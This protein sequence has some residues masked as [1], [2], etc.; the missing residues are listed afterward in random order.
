VAG[1]FQKLQELA[2]IQYMGETGSLSMT[3]HPPVVGDEPC[4]KS[5]V[6]CG[7]DTQVAVVVLVETVSITGALTEVS[8]WRGLDPSVALGLRYPELSDLTASREVVESRRCDHGR[9]PELPDRFEDLGGD[10]TVLMALLC[11]VL[12]ANEDVGIEDDGLPR[13]AVHGSHSPLRSPSSANET[14]V[15]PHPET[16]AQ[17]DNPQATPG[18][19]HLPCPALTATR[20]TGTSVREGPLRRARRRCTVR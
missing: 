19:P 9:V 16:V 2:G 3:N 12:R 1:R 5:L 14:L 6:E 18:T 13:I 11:I 17:A 7:K 8:G 10:L 15:N 4:G 20:M